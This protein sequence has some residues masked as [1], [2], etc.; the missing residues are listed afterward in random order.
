MPRI[1]HIKDCLEEIYGNVEFCQYCVEK[2]NFGV[3]LQ[4]KEVEDVIVDEILNLE[5][6]PDL[7][8]E[9]Y[10]MDFQDCNKKL[11]WEKELRDLERLNEYREG[12]VVLG[13]TRGRIG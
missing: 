3:K 4:F 13:T 6:I 11:D 12:N 8:F 1:C 7:N 9:P 2:L 10:E 5:E